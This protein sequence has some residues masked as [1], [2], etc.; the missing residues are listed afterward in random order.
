MP[1]QKTG[2]VIMPFSPTTSEDNWSEIFKDVFQPALKDCGY[3]CTCAQVTTGS[4]ITS[5]V[6][7]LIGADIVIADVTDR[8]ANVFYELGVRHAL[9]RGTIIVS[10]G[11]EHVPSDLKGYWFL[12]YGIRPGEVTAFKSEV[13]R[14]VKTIENDPQRS[15]NP[16]SDYLDKTHRSSLR[17]T[18][19]DNLN[20]LGAL[21]TELTGHRRAI[22]RL[23][24]T[25]NPQLFSY[26]CLELLLHTRYLDVGPELLR[27][28]YELEHR[29][30][31]LPRETTPD[32]SLLLSI[33]NEV[34]RVIRG[35]S[36]VKDGVAK[37]EFIEPT[38]LSTME[39]KSVGC[40]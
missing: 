40:C 29:L 10:K 8:N 24:S 13:K 5:I 31:S 6:E 15:D 14:I 2:F 1:P 34:E 11:T 32:K 27:A 28:C 35:V 4:L 21:F 37:G 39:W 19:R 26:G 9:R 38:T 33:S 17:E 22:E 16:V 30:K 7:R 12:T 18:N 23:I 3:T 36:S 20:K 25:G